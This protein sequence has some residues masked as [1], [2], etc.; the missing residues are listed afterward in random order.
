MTRTIVNPANNSFESSAVIRNE[1]QILENEIGGLGTPVDNEVV[2]GSGN[3]FTLAYIPIAGSEH[4]FALGQRLF[5]GDYSINE[6]T[7][8]ITTTASWSTGQIISDY[9]K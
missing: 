1:L 4:V 5:S 3:T 2:A 8:V 6:T 7:G 9:R